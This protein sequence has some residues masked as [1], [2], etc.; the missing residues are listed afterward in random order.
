MISR[1]QSGCEQLDGPKQ[2]SRGILV[3]QAPFPNPVEEKRAVAHLEVEPKP[4]LEN[5]PCK[6]F[7]IECQLGQPAFTGRNLL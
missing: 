5:C 7:P 3:P 1:D 6:A 4:C 2:E